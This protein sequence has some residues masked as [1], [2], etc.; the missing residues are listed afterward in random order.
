MRPFNC[1]EDPGFINVS[2]VLLYIG[3]LYGRLPG[4]KVREK[5]I[6]PCTNT[7]KRRIQTLT[8]ITQS[9]VTTRLAAAGARGELAFSSD[10]SS[11]KLES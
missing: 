9:E 11:V 6:L 5:D 10:L 2:Q 3:A 7:V 8:D 4:R 1:V